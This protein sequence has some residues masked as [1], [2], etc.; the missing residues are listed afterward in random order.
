VCVERT[1]IAATN[2]SVSKNPSTGS[3]S[4][5]AVSEEAENVPRKAVFTK[6]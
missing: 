4:R 6:K 1:V 2:G 5:T 3:G